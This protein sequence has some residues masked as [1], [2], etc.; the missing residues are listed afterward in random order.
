MTNFS[1][2]SLWSSFKSSFIKNLISLERQDV[3]M[4]KFYSE[5]KDFLKHKLLPKIAN[6]LSLKYY[7]NKEFLRVD[8]T[9]FCKRNQD[10]WEVPLIS[11]ESENVWDSSYE[12]VLKLLSINV[13]L[14]VLVLYNLSEEQLSQYI[15]SYEN[16]WDYMFQDFNMVST[17]VGHFAVMIFNCLNIDN[18]SITFS[19]Y[20]NGRPIGKIEEL[21]ILI[22]SC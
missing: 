5:R 13:P 3:E 17:N 8:Y 9:L 22:K 18:L 11:I 7:R 16:D 21:S 15:H 19:L 10:S 4:L 1:C 2:S 20:D 14:K 12:E 6:D